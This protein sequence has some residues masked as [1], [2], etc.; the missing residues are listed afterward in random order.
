MSTPGK[1]ILLPH[2][3]HPEQSF[4]VFSDDVKKKFALLDGCIVESEKTA[5]ALLKHFSYE[6]V[7]SFRELPLY[8][9]N[10]HT[11]SLIE[12]LVLLKSGQTIGL[13]SD[14]GLPC[15]ADPGADLVFE[16][17]K[18]G[19]AIEVAGVFSSVI[20]ALL[21]SGLASQAFYFAGYMPKEE[22]AFSAKIKQLEKLSKQEKLTVLFIETPYRNENCLKMMLKE[23]SLTSFIS[24]CQDLG[25]HSEHVYTDRV[26]RFSLEKAKIQ[27]SPAVFVLKA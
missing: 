2:F 5:R 23:L 3:I 1:L 14:A 4:E 6:K 10:E 13:I 19:I 12:L 15:L 22:P 17:K 27:K 8:T 25:S 9:L 16:A 20:Y 21:V 24:Y 11:T 18:L 7:P 26:D